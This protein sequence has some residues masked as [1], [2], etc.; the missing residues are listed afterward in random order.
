MVRK[1]SGTMTEKEITALVAAVAH[2]AD[3]FRALD[4]LSEANGW[5]LV[6]L[7]LA[8]R[9]MSGARYETPVD[10]ESPPDDSFIR[11]ARA[12]AKH[13]GAVEH[14]IS[15]DNLC[16]LVFVP[17]GNLWEPRRETKSRRKRS[18][19]RRPVV[20][21]DRVQIEQRLNAVA[22]YGAIAINA[23][24]E[25]A[26]RIG[27]LVGDLDHPDKVISS[28]AVSI[29]TMYYAYAL[30]FDDLHREMALRRKDRATKNSKRTRSAK[31]PGGRPRVTD[32]SLSTI[33]KRR[34]RARARA[35]MQSK[36]F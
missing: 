24:P 32:P 19:Q 12:I 34:Q 29:L 33:R 6:H 18:A 16:C 20:W 1:T 21:L 3:D 9:L 30:R 13:L 17:N 27:R 14:E 8:R 28:T 23:F 11:T 35:A 15:G 5:H 2:A 26:E 36:I 22:G 10:A 4:A 7:T 25:D 31:G